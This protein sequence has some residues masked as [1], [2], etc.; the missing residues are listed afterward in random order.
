MDYTVMIYTNKYIIVCRKQ[1]FS[2]TIKYIKQILS[3]NF[4]PDCTQSDYCRWNVSI[5]E[6]R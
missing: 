4:V 2:P 6:H 1:W 3:K 5:Q